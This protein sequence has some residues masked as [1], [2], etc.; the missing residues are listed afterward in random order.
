V[1]KRVSEIGDVTSGQVNF[2][3]DVTLP[4]ETPVVSFGKNPKDIDARPSWVN[5]DNVKTQNQSIV[6][7]EDPADHHIAGVKA[8]GSISGRDSQ[9]IAFGVKSCPGGHGELTL[10]VMWTQGE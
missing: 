4:V 5:T 2:G 9:T 10:H 8:V 1:A 3:C 7:V 6:N